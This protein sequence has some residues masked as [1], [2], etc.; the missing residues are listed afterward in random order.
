M[1]KRIQLSRRKGWRM[2]DN[3]VKVDRTNKTFGNIFTI[4]SNPSQFSAAL[5]SYCD[6]VQQAI[7]CFIYY[8]DTWMEITDGRWIEPLRGK[9]LACWCPLDQPCHADVLLELANTPKST[10]PEG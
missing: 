3:T 8:A 2:P 1:P 7:A 5:P 9:N 10:E 6:T 4:G